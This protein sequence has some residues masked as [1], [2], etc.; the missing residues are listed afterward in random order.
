MQYARSIIESYLK[1]FGSLPAAKS[2]ARSLPVSPEGISAL[3]HHILRDLFYPFGPPKDFLEKEDESVSASREFTPDEVMAAVS[4]SALFLHLHNSVLSHCF[5]FDQE[6]YFAK[7]LIPHCR[8]VT[9]LSTSTTSKP[10]LLDLTRV[11]FL[12]SQL[13][14]ELQDQWRFLFSTVTH[15]E[16]FSK[17]LGLIRDKG[18]TI[19]IVKG[20]GGRVFGG[21]APQSW[22]LGPKFYG[23]L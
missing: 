6:S 18:A 10:T 16:S 4:K 19:I 3:A 12:N 14:P 21:F 13:P 5:N 15:G 9:S 17:L 8:K 7:Y 11:M 20:N 1:C 23:R 22:T 2:W